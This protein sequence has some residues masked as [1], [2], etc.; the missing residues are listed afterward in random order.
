MLWN[1]SPEA[2]LYLKKVSKKNGNERN[3]PFWNVLWQ[4]QCL[5]YTIFQEKMI[6][7][8]NLYVYGV[9]D[10][11]EHDNVSSCIISSLINKWYLFQLGVGPSWSTC[12]SDIW[13][14]KSTSSVGLCPR[15]ARKISEILIRIERLKVCHSWVKHAKWIWNMGFKIYSLWTKKG[16]FF[17]E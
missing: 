17:S 9:F 16:F 12:S 13:T 15:L 14:N 4:G 5:V 1:F 3:I 11:H 8:V 6:N 2:E 10:I 7:K